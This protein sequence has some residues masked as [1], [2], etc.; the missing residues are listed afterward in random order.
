MSE[1]GPRTRT[2]GSAVFVAV[3]GALANVLLAVGFWGLLVVAYN[4]LETNYRGWVSEAFW[5][6]SWMGTVLAVGGF[7]LSAM[8]SWVGFR[9]YKVV[10]PWKATLRASIIASAW[11]L[12]ATAGG[13]CA[14]ILT[15]GLTGAG[16]TPWIGLIIALLSAAGAAVWS[17][18]AKKSTK[19]DF[20]DRKR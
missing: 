20:G 6:I 12:L 15:P 7:G 2:W 18:V 13:A 11:G 8:T 5:D 14:L 19:D 9:P 3:A 16:A 10:H 4:I 17:Y 1:R